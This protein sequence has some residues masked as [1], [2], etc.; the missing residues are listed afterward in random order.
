M[1]SSSCRILNSLTIV[2]P[3]TKAG[4]GALISTGSRFNCSGNINLQNLTIGLQAYTGGIISLGEGVN[5]TI[6]NVTNKLFSNT[7]VIY[8][9]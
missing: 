8:G 3:S 7:G 1:I 5:I 6:N 9:N 4:W 2:G